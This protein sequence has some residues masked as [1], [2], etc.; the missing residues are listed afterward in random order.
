MKNVSR[1]QQLTHAAKKYSIFVVKANVVPISPILVTVM[2]EALSF[3]ETSDLTRAIPED[4]ILPQCYVLHKE[5]KSSFDEVG[6]S[7]YK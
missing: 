6:C 2:M 7:I 4:G 5:V 3:S 1:N